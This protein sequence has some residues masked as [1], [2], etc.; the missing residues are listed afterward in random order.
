MVMGE[1]E[2]G[3]QTDLDFGI[4]SQE[5][6]E[7]TGTLEGVCVCVY[8]ILFMHVCVVLTVCVCALCV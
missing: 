8:L 6:V 1:R 3:L 4:T 2:H 7:R 5:E